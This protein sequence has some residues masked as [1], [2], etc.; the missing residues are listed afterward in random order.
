MVNSYWEKNLPSNF[1]KPGPNASHYEVSEFLT[2]KYV[3]KKW[4]DNDNWSNDPAWLFENKPAKFQKFVN[5]YKESLGIEVEHK[6]DQDEEPIKPK[7]QKPPTRDIAS[8]PKPQPAAVTQEINL[9]DFTSAP[10][11]ND[12]G[13]SDF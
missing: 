9:I 12:D 4:A 2:S 8:A 7:L 5:Y 3:H 1:K 13:F 11:K 6:D 10:S